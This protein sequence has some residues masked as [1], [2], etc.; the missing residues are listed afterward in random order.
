MTQI[1]FNSIMCYYRGDIFILH[2]PQI[3]NLGNFR[4]KIL[5]ILD[6][7]SWEF[8]TLIYNPQFLKFQWILFC[9]SPYLFSEWHIVPQLC[10]QIKQSR[11]RS[12]KAL[13]G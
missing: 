9:L 7:K 8:C 4:L 11:T 5:G 2:S 6:R 1:G 13:Y 10:I 3:E 12:H